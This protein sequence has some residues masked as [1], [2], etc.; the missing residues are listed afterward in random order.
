[1]Q[2]NKAVHR[3][4]AFVE[5]LA[6]A[7]ASQALRLAHFNAD[8]LAKVDEYLRRGAAPG[9]RVGTRPKPKW[10]LCQDEWALADTLKSIDV[11]ALAPYHQRAYLWA[12]NSDVYSA[13]HALRRSPGGVVVRLPTAQPDGQP[14]DPVVIQADARRPWETKYVVGV[15]AAQATIGQ[16][17]EF[18]ALDECSRRKLLLLHAVFQG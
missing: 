15:V 10:S 11:E 18:E 1:M 5:A 13:Q 6:A 12:T 3:F 4:V 2:I 8:T 14:G 17:A 7:G 16:G 9:L